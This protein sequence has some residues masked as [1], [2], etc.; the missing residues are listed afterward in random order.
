MDKDLLLPE[1]S[2]TVLIDN[3]DV[4]FVSSS[5]LSNL[6]IKLKQRLF[7]NI[8]WDSALKQLNKTNE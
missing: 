2:C 6:N 7:S 5:L 3:Q 8:N 1:N 4:N